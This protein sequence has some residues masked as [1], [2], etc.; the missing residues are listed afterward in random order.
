MKKIITLVLAFTLAATFA[1]ADTMIQ[2]SELPKKAQDCI[3]ALYPTAQ[4]QYA[5]KD[6]DSFDARLSNGAKLEFYTNGDWEKISD[7]AGIPDAGIPANI[8]KSVKQAYPQAKIIEIEKDWNNIEVKLNN[9]M[10]L[11]LDNAGKILAQ[12]MDD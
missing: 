12:K 4:V 5:E 6:F 2:P 9:N 10:E 1:F 11:K 8:L 7:Y 3:K